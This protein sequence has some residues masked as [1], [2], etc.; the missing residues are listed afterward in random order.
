MHTCSIHAFNLKYIFGVTEYSS[1]LPLKLD[2]YLPSSHTKYDS[3]GI[4]LVEILSI[5]KKHV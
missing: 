3:S 2:P 1:K 4:A 5:T